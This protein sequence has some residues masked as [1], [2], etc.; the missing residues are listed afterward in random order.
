MSPECHLR[1]R[2]R[3][4]LFVGQ[5][6]LEGT[7]VLVWVQLPRAERHVGHTQH[8]PQVRQHD[9]RHLQAHSSSSSSSTGHTHTQTP[10]GT[11]AAAAGTGH[12]HT[13]TDTCRHTAAAAAL[14]THTHRHLQVHSSSS[15]SSGHTHTHT[16]TCR[17]TAAA[18]AALEI[19]THTDTCRHTAAAAAA[20]D[21]HTHTQTPAGTQ[22]QQQQQWTHTHR[23][24][25]AHSSSSSSTG[26]THTHTHR[27]L[28]AHS[29]SSSS[30]GHT[31]THTDTCRHTAA[32]AAL[33]THTHTGL[34]R[35][36]DTAYS[37]PRSACCC[38]GEKW[39]PE[40]ASVVGV[41]CL[42]S[43][44]RS[45]RMQSMLAA[46]LHC[47]P[48]CRLG[49]R[50]LCVKQG[51]GKTAGCGVH[52]GS[53]QTV[54]SSGP[55]SPGWEEARGMHPLQGVAGSDSPCSPH[56]LQWHGLWTRPPPRTARCSCPDAAGVAHTQFWG[57]HSITIAWSS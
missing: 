10:A 22:Q 17:H 6:S 50:D 12:T 40:V 54:A 55:G 56:H 2:E 48:R 37:R 16:N 42:D 3:E 51:A 24:L 26:H 49:G 1:E 52:G 46:V 32:A 38:A 30:T 29:S 34:H 20:L 44:G 25:Q 39:P 18:A 9:P 21:T 19:H 7:A 15:S 53:D 41:S 4:Y 45:H 11:A 31:H 47:D 36:A 57:R 33:D 27:H 28:Q 43:A 14:D 5:Q 8:R 13:H 35:R 23:H